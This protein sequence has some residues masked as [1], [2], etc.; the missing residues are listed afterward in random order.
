MGNLQKLPRIFEKTRFYT[1]HIYKKR[2]IGAIPSGMNKAKHLNLTPKEV[3]TRRLGK[4]IPPPQ[5]HA[6]LVLCCG[7]R[8][9]QTIDNQDGQDQANGQDPF[10]IVKD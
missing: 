1:K 8:H 3:E 7:K 5:S 9:G 2:P 4:N 6:N 10:V